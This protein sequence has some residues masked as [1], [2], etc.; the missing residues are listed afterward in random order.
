MLLGFRERL[1]LLDV[2]SHAAREAEHV[3]DARADRVIREW[4]QIEATQKRGTEFL[5]ARAAIRRHFGVLRGLCHAEQFVRL[6]QRRL[7]DL[8]IAIAVERRVHGVV[9]LGRVEQAPPHLGHGATAR[10]RQRQ[11]RQ[12]FSGVTLSRRRLGRLEIGARDTTG[13]S[14]RNSKGDEF[15]HSAI[16]GLVPGAGFA[17]RAKKI[18]GM[19]TTVRIIMRWNAFRYEIQ[20]D[21]VATCWLSAASPSEGALTAL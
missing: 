18:S 8:Q 7:R 20:L 21:W 17:P 1:L 2:P 15:F 12:S 4:R 5:A 9:E 13:E 11:T 16:I 3:A 19:T 6:F 14:Q 10:G